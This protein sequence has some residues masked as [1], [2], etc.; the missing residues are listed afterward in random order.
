[1]PM[2][3]MVAAA[4]VL[5]VAFAGEARAT[6]LCGWIVETTEENDFHKLVLYLS[7]DKETE[8]LYKLGGQGI[9]DGSGHSH[10][11]SKGS[12]YLRDGQTDSA[13]SFG[14]T[15]NAPGKI[16]VI[17]EIH[18]KPADIFDEKPTPLLATFTF[19]RNVPESETKAPPVLAK[20]Q[21]ATLK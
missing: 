11:P 5:T 17:V 8:F 12:F 10:S 13:W 18:K 21:C 20:K 16:D 2:R 3:W 1:M 6:Q 15:L 19:Q 4:I 7:A 9:V 14:A